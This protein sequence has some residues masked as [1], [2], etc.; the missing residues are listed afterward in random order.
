MSDR[1]IPSGTDKRATHLTGTGGWRKLYL[2]FVT[3]L[4]PNSVVELGCGDP[5]FLAALPKHIQ[6]LA[7]DANADLHPLY[8]KAG[9]D[10]YTFDFDHEDS[11]I[12]LKGFDIAVCSDVFEHLLYP[13]K[14]LRLLATALS[15]EGVLFS[16]VPNEF[17]LRRT[18]K[19][20]LGMAESSYFFLDHDEWDYPHLRRF[21]D[22]G[23][24]HFLQTEF[25]HN[26]KITDLNYSGVARL[27]NK[28]R[29][30]VPYCLE[31]GPTYASTN[32]LPKFEQ[33]GELK[34]RIKKNRD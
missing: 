15:D 10:F 21:T 8:E 27:M 28:L 33:L 32:S 16:H 25:R 23:Y 9:I 3:E 12:T 1:E 6:R 20:M 11:P 17:R 24:R 34:A 30:P 26:L 2:K 14:S 31:G 18:V 19:I 7:L 13:Q 29:L 22:I 5:A 4:R